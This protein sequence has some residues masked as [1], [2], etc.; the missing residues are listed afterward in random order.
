LL[1]YVIREQNSPLCVSKCGK[2]EGGRGDVKTIQLKMTKP[3]KIIPYESHLKLLARELRKNSTLSEVLLWNK[4]KNK[5]FGV[6]FHR[7]VPIRRYI[8]DFYCH[9]LMLALEI[10][11]SS[12]IGK[13]ID[14]LLRQKELEID[15][16]R[17]LRFD[18]LEVK[19]DMSGVLRK[20]EVWI[21]ENKDF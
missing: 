16:V 11:G 7:Q 9:E 14:D 13:E 10:D 21:A 2:A 12:H 5:A 20:V 3:N 8:V 18:D 17:F 6:E 1:E 15:D 4:I 19:K